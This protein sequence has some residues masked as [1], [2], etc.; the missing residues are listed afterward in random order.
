MENLI[1]TFQEKYPTRAE[2]EKA[3]NNMTNE[4]IDELIN[5]SSNIYGK[6]FYSKY[7]KKEINNDGKATRD[8]NINA[9]AGSDSEC[10]S[11][12]YEGEESKVK[13]EDI[14]EGTEINIQPEP[15]AE[16][17][18][19]EVVVKA[20][21]EIEEHIFEWITIGYESTRSDDISCIQTCLDETEEKFCVEIVR[22]NHDDRPFHIYA[23]D[24]LK[25][26]EA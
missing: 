6:I 19:D 3:L 23:K 26:S 25:K 10:L 7:K 20:I 22:D 17:Y 18:F 13:I 14:K 2:K 1:D 16:D 8:K 9:Y 12:M 4:Q 21:N 11:Y 5:A 24:G 15:M